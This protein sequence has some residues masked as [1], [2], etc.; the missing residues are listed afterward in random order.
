MVRLLADPRFLLGAVFFAFQVW[1]LLHPQQPLV[2]RPF[3]LVMALGLVILWRPFGGTGR[4]RRAVDWIVDALVIAAV[5][6]VGLYYWLEFPRLST[7]MENVSPVL[8]IDM[9]AGAILVLLLFEGVRRTVGWTLLVVLLVFLLYGFFGSWLPGWLSFRGFAFDDAIE[10]MTMTTTGVLGIT[11]ATSVHFVFY[12]IAFGAIYSAVGGGQ[13]FID[14]ALR[15][16]GWAVGGAAKAAIV[17]SSLMG[18]ISGSA[19][20]NVSA[21]GVFTIPL[22]R[23]CGFSADRAAA[24]EAIASTG[25][26]LM[27]PI[28][29]VAAFVMA[30]LLSI[31][32][33]D[34]ALAGLIPALAFYVALLVIVDLTARRSGIGTLTSEDLRKVEP[35]LPRLHLLIPPVTLI[36]IL[37]SGYSASY[38]ALIATASCPVAAMLLPRTWMKPR[39]MVEAVRDATRQAAEVAVP[40]AAIG[41]IIA[42][43]VQ[44][45]LALKFSG[46]LI[47]AGG[48][49][50]IGS[51][52]LIIIGCIIMGMGLPTV[53]A[54]IIGAILYAPALRDL[55]VPLLSAHFFILYYCVLSMVTP[56]VA[57]AS[58]AAA[59]LANASAMR[60]SV[61]AFLMSLV[62]F[63]VPFAFVFDDAL[64]FQ[65]TAG[66]VA[67][68]CIGLFCGTGLWAVALGGYCWRSLLTRERALVGAVA[69]LVIF[70]P[71]LSYGWIAGLVAG[72]VLVVL[73]RLFGAA[74]APAPAATTA[75]PGE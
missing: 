36:A 14:V 64:L 20:A 15:V 16:A 51:L 61:R 46:S 32:Y 63:F 43:A 17:A 29:G 39:A 57:I 67:I 59:G 22:M 2:E 41:I 1:V 19:V 44:S 30:D 75:Q 28:M 53:A 50:L 21:T 72:A 11:T 45:N 25:G 73:F 55:G 13:L 68:A 56:P 74:Q 60:T 34:I 38:A 70:S 27:P 47:A 8:P 62:A 4:Q 65:G 18:T 52:A 33:A 31:P 9:A 71:T 35:I 10:I 5:I 42:V 40:I 12:F 26:Q 6:F 58:Y 69:L 54:Y 23:R 48:G 66:E 3:H 7:R 24:T 37:A 49:T